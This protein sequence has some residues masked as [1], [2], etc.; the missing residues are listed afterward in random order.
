MTG[1]TA[2][3]VSGAAGGVVVVAVCPMVMLPSW[4][5][6]APVAGG[7]GMAWARRPGVHHADLCALAERRVEEGCG[8]FAEGCDTLVTPSQPSHTLAACSQESLRR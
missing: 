6:V 1:G 2:K 3:D 4:M 7:V 5:K 8:H